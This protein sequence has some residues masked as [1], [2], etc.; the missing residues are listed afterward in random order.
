MNEWER[1]ERPVTRQRLSHR[2][3]ERDERGQS[4][5]GAALEPSWRADAD[6][7]PHEQPEMKP[8]V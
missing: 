8:L 6:Q 2:A 3:Q 5:E 7:A 4:G 1:L